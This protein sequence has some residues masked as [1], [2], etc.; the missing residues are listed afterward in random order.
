MPNALTITEATPNTTRTR[1]KVQT[2]LTKSATPTRIG[3]MG[4]RSNINRHK[5]TST[6]VKVESGCTLLSTFCWSWW[7]PGMSPAVRTLSL[8]WAAR[9]GSMAASSSP[10]LSEPTSLVSGSRRVRTS[11]A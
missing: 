4:L 6:K 10:N 1:P 7:L 9:M 8:G 11:T 5:S 3:V 2:R